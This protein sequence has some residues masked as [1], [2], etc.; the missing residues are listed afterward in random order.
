M[1]G[2]PPAYTD[3]SVPV[4]LRSIAPAGRSAPHQGQRGVR[5]GY[6]PSES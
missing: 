4:A 5:K 3:P 1:D 2:V 6:D